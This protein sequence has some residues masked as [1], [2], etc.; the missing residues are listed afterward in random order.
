MVCIKFRKL[1]ECNKDATDSEI[2]WRNLYTLQQFCGRYIHLTHLFKINSNIITEDNA[3][4]VEKRAKT[5]VYSLLEEHENPKELQG[6]ASFF[7]VYREPFVREF[8]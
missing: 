8:L 2:M 4:N 5:C 6:F 1:Y 7:W 3:K